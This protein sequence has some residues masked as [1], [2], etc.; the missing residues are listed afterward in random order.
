M[1]SDQDIETMVLVVGAGPVGL[2][3]AM[4]LAWRGIDVVVVEL[5][6]PGEPPPVKCNHT[7]ARSMEIFRRLGLA[8]K[9]REAGLPEDYP[10]DVTYSTT[11]TGIEL[12]RIPIPCRR[13][14]YAS[15]GYPDSDWPTPEPPHRINQIYL[16]PVMFEH[17][18]SMRQIRIVNRSI[19]EDFI[20]TDDGVEAAVCDLDTGQVFTI[21][22]RYL[23][24]CD[25][26]KSVIRKKMGVR[27]AGDAEISRVL[28]TH[29]RAPELL[30]RVP[31]K[32]AWMYH[33]VNPRQ[34]GAVVAI[35]GREQWLVHCSM[36]LDV[37]FETVDRDKAIRT[38]LGVDEN[39]HYDV[40]SK[41]DWVSRRL[42]AERFRDRRVFICGDAAHIWIPAGGYGM[43]A[44]IADATNLSWMLAAVLN[45]WA[46]PDILD[47]YEAERHAITEQVS[48]F[49]MNTA[50]RDFH[51][52]SGTGAEIEAPGPAGDELRSSTGRELYELNVRQ[53]CCAGLNFGYYYDRSPLI[54]YDGET[55]PS[56]TMDQYTASTV[57]GCRTPHVWLQ[58]GRSLY[59]AFGPEFTLIRFDPALNVDGIISAFRTRGVPLALLDV[60]ILSEPYREK[61]VLSRPDQ[62]IAW[63]GDAEPEN[64]LALVDLVR[65][66][67]RQPAREFV[68]E[69]LAK[70]TEEERV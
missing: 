48:H 42:V 2:T 6:P 63:R 54:A 19:V 29:I 70:A 13:D 66:A 5:R 14:R 64:P 41:E 55:P 45:G 23:I 9:V 68:A 51:K 30:Q 12:T 3:L 47:A 65:G 40:I 32:P 7:S 26:G 62:H 18:A 52:R 44:G 25:G 15:V 53:F 56:Y 43:N 49:A 20:Q 50:R 24:G 11:M 34:S 21:S 33:A 16:E 35:D 1:L 10:N 57:P 22:S 59:D 46:E 39:F 37:D 58:D 69:R 27:L 8:Q 67:L 4:D 17:A 36:R 60:D 61:L 38:V 31:D 28:S